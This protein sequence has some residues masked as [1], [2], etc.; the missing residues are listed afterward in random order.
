MSTI[1]RT[2]FEARIMIEKSTYRLGEYQISEYGDGVLWWY[3]HH[4]LGQQRSGR[5][6]VHGDLLVIGQFSDEESGFLKREFLDRLKNL[7]PWRKTKFYCFASELR[8]VSSGQTLSEDS[9]NRV[10][11]IQRISRTQVQAG[12][13]EASGTF[14]LDRYKVTVEAGGE[15]LWQGLEGTETVVGGQCSVL[16]GIL[17]IGPKGFETGGQS[18]R[19]FLAELNEIPPW[20]RTR[21][22]GHSLALRA[23]EPQPQTGHLN[24]IAQGDTSRDHGFPGSAASIFWKATQEAVKSLRPPDVKFKIP[25]SSFRRPSSLKFRIPTPSS[26]RLRKVGF[27]VLIPLLFAGMILGLILGTH[28]LE[29]KSHHH[30]ASEKHHHR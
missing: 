13:D 22:W 15:I 12:Q 6:F 21:M 7:P 26:Q 1:S 2:S 28:S 20:N 8:D 30:H 19:K 9:K 18:R 25:I 10:P 27:L 24:G 14:R 3:A 5:C 16:S 29:E 4:G 11:A 17:F 23:C